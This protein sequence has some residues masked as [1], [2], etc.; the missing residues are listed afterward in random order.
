MTYLE[1]PFCKFKLHFDIDYNK[2]QN[3]ISASF[4]KIK[5]PY[6]SFHV[7]VNGL[8]DTIKFIKDNL[9]TFKLRLFVDRTIMDDAKLRRKLLSDNSVQLV[10]YMCSGFLDDDKYHHS[11]VFGM[12]VRL[13]P[14][15]NFKN[16]DAGRIMVWDIELSRR[17][18][19][20]FKKVNDIIIKDNINYHLIYDGYTSKKYTIT[21]YNYLLPK[22]GSLFSA[23]RLPKIYIVNYLDNIHKLKFTHERYVSHKK[24]VDPEAKIKYG[25][26]E[27]FLSNLLE[28][29]IDKNYDFGFIN[30]YIITI[31]IYLSIKLIINNEKSID[32]IKKILGK[33]Y[34]PGEDISDYIKIIDKLFYKIGINKISSKGRYVAKNIISLFNELIEHKNY[35]WISKNQLLLYD[36]Y[37]K[38]VL[39]DLSIYDNVKNIKY[40]IER[41]IIGIKGGYY[42]KYIKYKKKYLNLK[43]NNTI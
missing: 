15:F 28:D 23:K 42:D 35:S 36:K 3:I 20:I 24:Q 32:Y 43:Y 37:H 33:Y 10:E 14:L 31:P 25:M 21:K 7:Y 39:Y 5:K 38:N 22:G 26:D 13:V 9:P 16:N 6:K 27:I 17:E 4:F 2:K 8:M 40:I 29:L 11:G 12:F 19:N 18:R 34:E 41:D 1:N 30:V